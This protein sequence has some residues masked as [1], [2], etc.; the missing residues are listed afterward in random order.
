MVTTSKQET[1]E[2][3]NICITK[4]DLDKTCV[5][6]KL[7]VFSSGLYYTY[8]STIEANVIVNQKFADHDKFVV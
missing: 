4:H 6:E 3:L 7:P 8:I 1:K 2:V 5:L